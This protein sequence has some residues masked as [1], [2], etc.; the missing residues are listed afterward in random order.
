[1]N[2]VEVNG[3]AL[4]YELSGDGPSTLVLVHEMGGTLESWNLVVPLFSAKR[5]VLRYD[6]RGAGL[7]QK[8]RG[9][10]SIDTMTDDLVALM[11][12][13]GVTGRVAFAGVAV[14]GAIAMH[15]AVRFP[16]RAAAVVASSPAVGIASDRRPALLARVEK[17]EREGLQAVTDTLDLSYPAE[18]RGDAQRFAAFRARWLGSDPLSFGAIYRMLMATD[19]QPELPRIACP[20]LILA[21]AFD[22]TRPPALVEPVARSIPNARYAVLQSG[23]YAPLQTPDLYARAVGEFLDAV[24]A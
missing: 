4:R 11:D 6:T 15:T 7:S 24:G 20:A 12:A 13:L 17:M 22:G 19:L 5:R 1:M 2:F 18:L 16:Q 14:G 10:L 21:G 23:H 8:I 3:T 9:P